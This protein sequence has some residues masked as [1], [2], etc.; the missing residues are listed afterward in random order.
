LGS[1]GRLLKLKVEN[2][3]VSV[4]D[5]AISRGEHLL[6]PA[7]MYSPRRHKILLLG[8][9]G[10]SFVSIRINKE[11]AKVY[12]RREREGWNND[13]ATYTRLHSNTLGIH[14][15][16]T[17]REVPSPSSSARYSCRVP[18]TWPRNAFGVQARANSSWHR[19]PLYEGQEE[20]LPEADGQTSPERL[21]KASGSQMLD[22]CP[23]ENCTRPMS[24]HLRGL[25]SCTGL[26]S[27]GPNGPISCSHPSAKE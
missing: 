10:S 19:H 8:V 2:A 1:N 20:F 5:P 6:F 22:G 25:Y 12:G 26:W 15:L 9:V 24:S 27:Q 13:L 16:R 3:L 4:H 21:R 18:S 11:R 23:W 7:L 14:G 17:T